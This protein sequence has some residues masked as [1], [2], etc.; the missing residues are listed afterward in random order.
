M[1]LE[2]ICDDGP[3]LV[4]F[5]DPNPEQHE[6]KTPSLPSSQLSSPKTVDKLHSSINKVRREIDKIEEVL[7]EASPSLGKKLSKIFNG[8][9]TQAELGAQQ[10]D[11][12]D[13]YLEAS[14]RRKRKTTRRQ[15]KAGG[16][17][18]IK[19]ANRKIEE[20]EV[21]E[22]RAAWKQRERRRI[23]DEKQRLRAAEEEART[24]GIIGEIAALA[25]GDQED[26]PYFVDTQGLLG[27]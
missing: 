9:L 6:E 8:S 16:P 22:M 27:G 21:A 15:V 24:G 1:E 7:Q 14:H 2:K 12:L 19:D 23:Q 20:R 25:T 5:K 10:G 13:R 18:H 4:F 26:L 3:D 11:D 17:L